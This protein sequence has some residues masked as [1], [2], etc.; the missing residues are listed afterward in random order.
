MS[1]AALGIPG[2]P[3]EL[4]REGFVLF[5]ALDAAELATVR[6]MV[7]TALHAVNGLPAE[8]GALDERAWRAVLADYPENPAFEHA[9]IGTKRARTLARGHWDRFRQLSV[10]RFVERQIGRFEVSAEERIG[11][12]EV[13]WRLARPQ[14]TT[15]VGPLHADGWFWDSNPTWNRPAVPHRRWKVWI[16]LETSP[17]QG[18]FRL[19]PGSHARADVRYGTRLVGD[20]QKPFLEDPTGA[21]A[22]AAEAIDIP[23][24]RGILFDDRLVHGGT[25]TTAPRPRVSI[26][27]T[28]LVPATP[29]HG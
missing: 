12:P 11:H 18:G 10:M 8:F 3:E 14:A 19:V 22:A 29:H 7:A 6:G 1:G 2:V 17:G 24:G 5:D 21:I 28:C 25:V 9:R 20:K 13:Y 16:A 27:F 4:V 26:E 15:D 23:P